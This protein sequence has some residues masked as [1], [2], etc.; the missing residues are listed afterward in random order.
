MVATIE[1]PIMNRPL[2]RSTTPP[3]FSP[4]HVTGSFALVCRC[5]AAVTP[6]CP[7][8]AVECA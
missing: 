4:P 6:G 1:P 3:P 5:G 2:D 8:A 7:F